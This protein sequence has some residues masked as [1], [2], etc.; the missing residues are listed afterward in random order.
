MEHRHVSLK[1]DVAKCRDR[2]ILCANLQFISDRKVRLRTLGIKEQKKNHT[3]FYLKTALDEVIEQYGIKNDQIYSITTDNG[4]NMINCVR[5]FSE[6]EVTERIGN[7]D[8]PSYSSWQSDAEEL[9]SDE[10]NSGTLNCINVK[11]FLGNLSS[12]HTSTAQAG[13]M[14]KG[15]RCGAHTL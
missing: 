6:E 10:D 1:A 15:V 13:N 14:W 4:A 12:S 9:N 5:L 7:A 11:V 3:D 8:H 2:S